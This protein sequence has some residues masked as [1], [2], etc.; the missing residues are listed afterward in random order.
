MLDR[1]TILE[2]IDFPV[3]FKRDPKDAIFL[4]CAA[5]VQ[6]DYFLTGDKD[7]TEAERYFSTII[8]SVSTFKRLIID[9]PSTP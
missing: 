2:E 5:A 7:F 3:D 6:A 9:S 8:L 4:S 1:I